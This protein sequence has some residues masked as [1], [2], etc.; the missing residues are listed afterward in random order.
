MKKKEKL[1]ENYVEQRDMEFLKLQ[2]QVLSDR[3][4]SHNSLLWNIPSLLFVALTLLWNIALCSDVDI[5]IRC[6]V[7]AISFIVGITAYQTFERVRVMEVADAE[8]LF[9][10]EKQFRM[11]NSNSKTCPIMIVNHR[12][13]ER[14]WFSNGKELTLKDFF[15]KKNKIY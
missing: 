4:I 12:L 8:Q 14:T 7:S 2:Y 11:W 10:I 9:L 5:I 1:K 6:I 15:I 13:D 3:R